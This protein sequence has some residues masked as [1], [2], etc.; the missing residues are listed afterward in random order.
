MYS[1]VSYPLTPTIPHRGLLSMECGVSF[2]HT[3]TTPPSPAGEKNCAGHF[4]HTP[5]FRERRGADFFF[6]FFFFR[7]ALFSLGLALLGLAGLGGTT[8]EHSISTNAGSS[9]IAVNGDY[10]TL[11]DTGLGGGGWSA[12]S[13]ARPASQ[14]ARKLPSRPTRYCPWWLVVGERNVSAGANTSA[15]RLSTQ[16]YYNMQGDATMHACITPYNTFPTRRSCNPPWTFSCLD[17]R[18]L[19][20]FVGPAPLSA[21]RRA[22]AQVVPE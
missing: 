8:L 4:H 20:L 19:S 21:S 1:A 13:P 3:S 14:P 16:G 15:S 11:Q 6:L 7:P 22:S 9:A 5:R 12:R 18:E 17:A 10:C 2:L